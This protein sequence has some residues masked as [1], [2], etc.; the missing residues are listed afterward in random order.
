LVCGLLLVQERVIE[1]SGVMSSKQHSVYLLQSD[2][3]HQCSRAPPLYLPRCH[4]HR[5]RIAVIAS[6]AAKVPSPGQTVYAAGKA[7]LWGYFASL[8]TEV[9]DQ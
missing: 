4:N 1:G 2:H 7:A 5:G 3:L 9:A 6:M 8:A